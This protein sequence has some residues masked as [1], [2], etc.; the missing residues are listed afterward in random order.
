MIV[1]IMERIFGIQVFLSADVHGKTSAFEGDLFRFIDARCDAK[2]IVDRRGRSVGPMDRWAVA[3]VVRGESERVGG[4][5]DGDGA[6]DGAVDGDGART[7]VGVAA[8]EARA[9]RDEGEW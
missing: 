7:S 8:R 9:R 1:C 6:A 4:D 5:S 2:T 3:I